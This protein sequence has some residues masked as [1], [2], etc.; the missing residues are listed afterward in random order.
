MK[1]LSTLIISLFITNYAWAASFDCTLVEDFDDWTVEVVL[2]DGEGTA[3]FFDN[4]HWSTLSDYQNSS[5]ESAQTL[6][7][8]SGQDSMY[9]EFQ[10]KFVFNETAGTAVLSERSLDSVDAN[11]FEFTCTEV[12]TVGACYDIFSSDGTSDARSFQIH[13]DAFDE[14]LADGDAALAVVRLIAS[15]QGCSLDAVTTNS[16]HVRAC[17]EIVPGNIFSKVCYVE[18]NLGYFTVHETLPES[19]MVTWSRWD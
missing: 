8:F 15:I 17:Q 19:I 7:T 11:D 1:Y 14:E 16:T 13:H 9:P 18:T 3:R 2:L 4:D 12:D 5:L 6:H 10:Y